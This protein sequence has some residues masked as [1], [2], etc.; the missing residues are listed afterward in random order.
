MTYTYSEKGFFSTEQK[1]FSN[2]EILN[3]ILQGEEVELDFKNNGRECLYFLYYSYYPIILKQFLRIGKFKW[4]NPT[5]DTNINQT[6]LLQPEVRLQLNRLS[7][8]YKERLKNSIEDQGMYFP[9]LGTKEDVIWFG[10]HRW[11]TLKEFN[12]NKKFL[13]IITEDFS[14]ELFFFPEVK[15]EKQFYKVCFKER[16]LGLHSNSQ[17]AKTRAFVAYADFMGNHQSRGQ[18]NEKSPLDFIENE[19]NFYKF[20]NNEDQWSWLSQLNYKI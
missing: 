1:Y 13:F 18:F 16:T 7:Y 11:F 12:Y 17:K 3:L 20:L 9:F 10:K 2:I 5:I 6:I 14:D 19:V 4:V 15:I 8:E